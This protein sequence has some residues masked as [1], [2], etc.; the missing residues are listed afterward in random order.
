MWIE[1]HIGPEWVTQCCERVPV[2]LDGPRYVCPECGI[3]WES[4]REAV[5]A[6]LGRYREPVRH[7]PQNRAAAPLTAVQGALGLDFG[8]RPDGE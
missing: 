3:I 4:A 6:V 8:G 5:P 7:L 1:R 2:P